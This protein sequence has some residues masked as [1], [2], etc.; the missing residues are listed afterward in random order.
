MRLRLPT[1][2]TG[3]FPIS[4]GNCP[5]LPHMLVGGQKDSAVMISEVSITMACNEYLSLT[6]RTENPRLP[7]Q[8][9]LVHPQIV[10]VVLDL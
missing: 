6:G 1:L 2:M 10:L 8:L 7:T 3:Q 4:G 5:T 9:V